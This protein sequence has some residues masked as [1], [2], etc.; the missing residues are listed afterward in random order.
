M[1]GYSFHE[2]IAAKFR[3]NGNNE[4]ISRTKESSIASVKSHVRFASFDCCRFFSPGVCTHWT[5][6]K[7][8][9]ATDAVYLKHVLG[10]RGILCIVK[11]DLIYSKISFTKIQQQL[12]IGGNQFC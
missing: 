1:E 8:R 9:T 7:T 4:F 3:R 6:I 2:F 5:V 10:Y 12:I 11:E